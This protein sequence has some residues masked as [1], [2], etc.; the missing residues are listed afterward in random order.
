[1]RAEEAHTGTK[2]SCTCDGKELGQK[3]MYFD[4]RSPTVEILNVETGE[5]EDDDDSEE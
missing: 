1:M 2:A 4:R 5:L 3:A